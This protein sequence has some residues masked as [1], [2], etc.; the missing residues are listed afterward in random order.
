MH[1]CLPIKLWKFER[2]KRYLWLTHVLAWRNEMN[3]LQ[4]HI[5]W[6]PYGSTL[7]LGEYAF[8]EHQIMLAIPDCSR[9]RIDGM[10]KTQ[11]IMHST[12]NYF[13]NTHL[14]SK[15]ILCVQGFWNQNILQQLKTKTIKI[16]LHNI[17]WA[18]HNATYIFTFLTQYEWKTIKMKMDKRLFLAYSKG[19]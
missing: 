9:T 15:L 13:A 12:I 2:N 8:P 18:C 5:S 19:Y 7:S 16:H 6:L 1:N 14:E 11:I 4:Y 17:L 3:Y 10:G